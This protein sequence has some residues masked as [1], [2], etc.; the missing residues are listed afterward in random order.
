MQLYKQTAVTLV[1]NS[2]NTVVLRDSN[3]TVTV[4]STADT[5]RN[6][7]QQTQDELQ[8]TMSNWLWES[9]YGE[10]DAREEITVQSELTLCWGEGNNCNLHCK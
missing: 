4:V 3:S 10:G 9:V 2:A 5:G 6:I 7:A 8:A 1:S